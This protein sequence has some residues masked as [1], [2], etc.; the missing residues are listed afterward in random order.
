M[1]NGVHTT[2]DIRIRGTVQGVGFRPFVYRMAH[3][4]GI[5]GSVRNGA[6]GV[7]ILA[8]GTAEALDAFVADVRTMAPPLA[9]ITEM[10]VSPAANDV[11]IDSFAIVESTH[12]EKPLVDI[13]R[14]TAT[15]D[16][17][18]RELRSRADR[19]HRHPFIN[20]TNCGP[21]FTI[22]ERLPYDRD[23]TTMATFPMCERCRAEYTDPMDRRFHAQPVCCHECGPRL[24]LLDSE[25]GEVTAA[26]PIAATIEALDADA[27]VAVKGLGGFHLACRAD[28]AVAVDTLRRRKARE[29]KPLALMVRNIT[30]ADRY[31]KI[32]EEE[33]RLLESIERPITIVNRSEGA[34]V[35]AEGVAPGV[36]TLGIMLP[37]TPLHHLLFDTDRYDALVM[38]SANYSGEPI[39]ADNSDTVHRLHGVADLFLDRKS[40]V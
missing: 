26:D 32:D 2:Y 25:G 15:C 40:V 3:E 17:C 6:G 4:R 22:I 39:C 35:L 7:E 16:D 11:D 13:T 23:T 9:H 34:E 24:R 36:T 27:I 28:S 37:Y 33:R 29:Q 1:T 8:R 12:G 10:H 38:T 18:L 21:R 14:D 20:C 19:R 30:V 31:A 5:A